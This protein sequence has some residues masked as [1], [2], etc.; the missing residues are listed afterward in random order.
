SG[1]VRVEVR[2]LGTDDAVR[3]LLDGRLVASSQGSAPT[4]LA[5]DEPG[6]HALTAI[7]ESGAW[8]RIGFRVLSR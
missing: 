3:W 6:P 2:A 8:A 1:P 5:L 7:A 4:R